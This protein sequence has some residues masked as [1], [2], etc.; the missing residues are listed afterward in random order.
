MKFDNLCNWVEN[1]A[2]PEARDYGFFKAGILVT[3]F[4][5]VLAAMGVVWDAEVTPYVQL[6]KV[7]YVLAI[8][9]V[10]LLKYGKDYWERFIPPRKRQVAFYIAT[11]LC[12]AVT[13]AVALLMLILCYG[14]R[15]MR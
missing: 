3:L 7:V 15:Y 12:T 2:I 14:F 11:V 13:A 5:S 9:S 6:E 1:K 10:V 4:F 8:A